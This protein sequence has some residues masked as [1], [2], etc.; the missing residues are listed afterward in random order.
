MISS[1]AADPLAAA[2]AR[3]VASP[4]APPSLKSL[5]QL[6]GLSP[7]QLTRSF[8]ARY[9]VSP[10]ELA[11]AQKLDGLKRALRQ[12][13]EVTDAIY[14]AGFGSPSRVYGTIE[15]HLGMTPGRYR[16]GAEG[17]AIRY[18]IADTPLGP[19]LV[20][21]TDR[22]LCAV[23]LGPDA[24][25]LQRG[26]A[27]EFPRAALERVDE[28]A[29][30]WIAGVIARVSASLGE[31]RAHSGAPIPAD[32]R[33]TAFQWQV[34]RELMRIPAGETRSYSEIAAAIGRPKAARAVA[35]ACASNRLAL[36]VPCHR[37]IRDDGSLGGYRWGLARKTK[38]L[39]LERQ[40]SSGDGHSAARSRPG[41]ARPRA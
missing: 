29:D 21:T 35:R 36:I 10:K 15:R 7:S 19:L 26:L 40:R 31:S 23:T 11:Q 33:A 5:S 4:E 20:A 34:W 3:I 28:G 16:R 1:F 37:V 25:A 13:R 6:A 9:G 38:A 14:D 17:I 32:L 12:G 41:A 39:A 8:R 30:Q 27:A 18:T 2:H 24:A 22:G